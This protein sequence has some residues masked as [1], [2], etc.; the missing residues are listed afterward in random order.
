MMLSR[1]LALTAAVVLVVLVALDALVEP[2]HDVRNFE[3]VT[4]MVESRAQESFRESSV[5][6]GGL[7]QQDLVEG[8]IPRGE[9]PFPYGAEPAEAERA[10]RELVNPF[11]DASPEV[12]QRGRRVFGI[13]CASCHDAKGE[14]RG[15]VVQRGM[16]PPPS[17]LAARA[18]A[19]PDGQMFHVVTL[20]QGNMRPHAAQ[21]SVEDRW[22]AIRWIRVL[23]EDAR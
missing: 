6:P 8:V 7:T 10:G 17:L 5:L 3:L 21:V 16:L 1:E 20:G 15:A 14:G 23:Q 13:F 22:K 19:M 9:L 2:R 12:L 11:A 4:E 18:L